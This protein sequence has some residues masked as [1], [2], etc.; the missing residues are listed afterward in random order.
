MDPIALVRRLVEEKGL[1]Q[2]SRDLGVSVSY[3]CNMM[4][5]RADPGPLVLEALGLERVVTY[6]KRPKVKADA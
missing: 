6:R 3:V 2:A 1:S 4:K 5:G